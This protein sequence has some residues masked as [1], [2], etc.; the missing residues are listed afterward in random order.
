MSRHKLYISQKARL[1][2]RRDQAN[3][4]VLG[5]HDLDW[6][7]VM[8]AWQLAQQPRQDSLSWS[9]FRCIQMPIDTDP[10]VLHKLQQFEALL[11]VTRQRTARRFN[12]AT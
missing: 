6:T 10:R 3:P 9:R 12:F 8:V 5:Y 1:M 7:I 4:S 2:K 11:V